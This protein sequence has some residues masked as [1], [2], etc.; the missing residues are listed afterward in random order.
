MHPSMLKREIKKFKT[1]FSESVFVDLLAK[2]GSWVLAGKLVY[3][4]KL[5]KS[6]I[7]DRDAAVD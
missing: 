1:V 2:L 4:V 5:W 6:I 3:S 7:N